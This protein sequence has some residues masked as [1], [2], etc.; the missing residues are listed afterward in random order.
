MKKLLKNKA[1]L[2]AGGVIL[3][4]VLVVIGAIVF[5]TKSNNQNPQE[6]NAIPTQVPIPTIAADSL[7][8]TLKNGD[9]GKTVIAEIAKI[10]GIARVEYELSYTAKNTTGNSS[11]EF[12]EQSLENL[13]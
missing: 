1:T 3:V 10:D 9:S 6:V 11:I 7:G 13:I 5:F 12:Q 2:I 4:L 8:L